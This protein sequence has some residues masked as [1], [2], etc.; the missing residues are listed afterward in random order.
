[1]KDILPRHL[2]SGWQQLP[3]E[4]LVTRMTNGISKRQTK[5]GKGLPVSRIE[6]ISQ[7]IIDLSR[8]GFLSDLTVPEIE[9]YRLECGDLL[10][11][12]INSD[13]HLGKT[14]VFSMPG[15]ILLH[16]MNLLLIRVDRK[17]LLPV[18]LHWLFNYYRV[19]GLFMS[20][21]QHAV[22]QSSINQRKLNALPIIVPPITDQRRIV[23]EIEKQFTRLDAGVTAMRRV[24]ANLKRYRA[25][26]LKAAC[27]GR[28]VSLSKTPRE[29]GDQL[30]ARI[31][32]ERRQNW[33]GRGK[34]T[35]PR[36]PDTAE[37]PKLP[38]DWTWARLEQL[39]VTYGGLTINPKRAKLPKQLPYLRVANVYANELRLDEIEYIG[40][41][42]AE[43][44]KLLV[45][46]GDLLIV[47]G[48][49]SKEQI[50]RLA[51]WDGS[52]DSCV[53]QNHLIKVRAVE[54]RMPKWILY[55]LQSRGGRKYVELVASST[56]GLFTLSVNK[57]G[58]LPIPVPPLAEQTRIV[59][60]VERRLSVVAEL[61]AVV[62][63]NLKRATRLRQSIL[64]KAFI[65]ALLSQ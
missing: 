54:P 62:S 5:D 37:L 48:N 4:P 18:F 41:A 50:G 39:G 53:H 6:T 38:K 31:L 35:E 17:K 57:V 26:V 36:P 40:V 55:W 27:E 3:L 25:A 10:F 45:R 8:V 14:A 46:A 32:T 22:N 43:L 64:Q 1:M 58:N 9:K 42:D 19:A 11:S 33:R 52:I 20:I 30:L 59:A 60:E 28:L 29:T 49:G 15:E 34:Y 61:D 51:I 7:G 13:L 47:E 12:H 23:A 24:Q 16:G 44:E 56:S 63:A 2:P 21:A 65:G